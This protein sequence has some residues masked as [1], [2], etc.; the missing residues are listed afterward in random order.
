MPVQ[1]T[2]D[3]PQPNQAAPSEPLAWIHVHATRMVKRPLKPRARSSTSAGVR[4]YKVGF[5]PRADVLS[6]NGESHSIFEYRHAVVGDMASPPTSGKWADGCISIPFRALVL[7][8]AIPQNLLYQGSLPTDDLTSVLLI[9]KLIFLAFRRRISFKVLLNE[10]Q[11]W[12][13]RRWRLASAPGP[14]THRNEY[15]LYTTLGWQYPTTEWA[16]HLTLTEKI[17]AKK[18]MHRSKVDS[19]FLIE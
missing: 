19:R 16:N 15:N 4:N 8:G 12:S 2:R 3:V 1:A 14:Q 18:L 7:L 10:I 11:M 17:V 6:F 9:L 5:S 13:V